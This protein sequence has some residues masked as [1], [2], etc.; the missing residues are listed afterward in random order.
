MDD[1]HVYIGFELDESGAVVVTPAWLTWAFK[2]PVAEFEL[3]GCLERMELCNEPEEAA[4]V[5]AEL[6]KPG[7]TRLQQLRALARFEHRFASPSRLSL[8]VY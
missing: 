5:M 7:T 4:R 2:Q 1:D 3:A 6:R 8:L